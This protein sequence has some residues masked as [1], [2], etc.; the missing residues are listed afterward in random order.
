MAEEHK[1]HRAEETWLNCYIEQK[2]EID[3]FVLFF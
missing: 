3:I 1:A 2:G